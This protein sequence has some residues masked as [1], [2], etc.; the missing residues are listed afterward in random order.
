MLSVAGERCPGSAG[1]NLARLY[2]LME[3]DKMEGGRG[4]GNSICDVR[5]A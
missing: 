3:T 1:V 4:R 2:V 5:G